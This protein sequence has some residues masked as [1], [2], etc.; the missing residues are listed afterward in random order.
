MPLPHRGRTHY[1]Q[2]QNGPAPVQQLCCTVAGRSI[3]S[4]ISLSAESISLHLEIETPDDF[5]FVETLNAHGWRRLAPFDSDDRTSTLRR[6]EQMPTGDVALLTM[7]ADEC[8]IRIDVEG[9]ADT[10]EILKRVRVMFQLNVP[11]DRF[12]SYCSADRALAHIPRK[13]QGRMLCSPTL[14]EDCCKVILTTNT[15]WVQTVGMTKRLVDAYGCPV[16]GDPLRRAFP[17]PQQVAEAPYPEFEASA[18]FGYRNLAIHT[19]AAA[20][21]NGEL[22]LELY[23]DPAL[24]GKELRK[25]LLSLRGV[26]PYA[27]SCLMIYLGRYDTVN[28]DSWARMMVSK[29]LGRPVTDAD[30]H[31]FFETYGEWRGLVYHFFPWK[32]EEPPY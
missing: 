11:I 22:D 16:P 6:V 12:H 25:R 19:L 32:E 8:S 10:E 28:V 14:W 4:L 15:T 29:E 18:R 5:S 31:E 13:K 26:G 17:S 9:D 3:P 21:A 1:R 27:A 30:V 2:L 23:R 20:I 7:R 24:D